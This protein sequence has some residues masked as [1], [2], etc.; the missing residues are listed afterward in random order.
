MIAAGTRVSPLALPMRSQFAHRGMM[1]QYGP[2]MGWAIG[3]LC[4]MPY[5]AIA[6]GHASSLQMGNILCILLLIPA[7]ALRWRHRPVFFYGLL[8]APLV[9]SSVKAGLAGADDLDL[10]FK[11]LNVWV[12]TLITLVIAQLFLPRYSL[13]ILS[14]IAVAAI[15]HALVGLCQVYSFS[16]GEFPFASF[17]V[18]QSFADVQENA[19]VIAKYIQRPFG[20]FPEPSAMASSL[21]PWLVFW[22]AEL[23]GVVRL[24]NVL[25]RWQRWLFGAAAT[26]SLV[27]IIL[28]SSGH[29]L[30]TSAALLLVGILWFRKLRATRHTF[31]VVLPI[32]SVC[33]PL[34]AWLTFTMLTS[35]IEGE[36]Q[37]NNSSWD[38]RSNSLIVGFQIYSH[39]D[40]ATILFGLGSGLSVPA[41]QDAAHYDAVWSVLLTYLYETGLVGAAVI[42]LIGAYLLRVWRASNLNPA[43]IAIFVVWLVGVTFTTSYAQLLPIWIALAWLSVWPAVCESPEPEPVMPKRSIEFP[44]PQLTAQ[45]RRTAWTMEER[46]GSGAG[47]V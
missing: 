7:F 26:G 25:A 30:I 13:E 10:C 5:P 6:I 42:C 39:G 24:R 34:V 16:N 23:C 32:I 4:F 20:I 17:Y 14:G 12:V 31:A 21:A 22:V 40:P 3:F 43:Y 47:A 18:N 35:R 1:E 9:I 37:V 29:M 33:L 27:L 19:T 44:Q 46:R 36:W 15:L 45:P 38:D 8:L 2:L 11:T 41:V 28:S